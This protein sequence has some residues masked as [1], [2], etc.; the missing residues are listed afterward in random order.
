MVKRYSCAFL[1][2]PLLV[3]LNANTL[4]RVIIE[5]TALSQCINEKLD[6]AHQ[7]VRVHHFA[8]AGHTSGDVDVH[9]LGAGEVT[10]L[11]QPVRKELLVLLLPLFPDRPVGS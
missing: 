8:P 1:L 4:W 9:R 2:A 5:D 11:L 7:I 10:V 6:A 3:D